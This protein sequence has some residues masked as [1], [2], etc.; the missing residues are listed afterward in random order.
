MI[1]HEC[2]CVNK[3]QDF[4]FREGQT[5]AMQK[6]DGIGPPGDV[7]V[8]EYGWYDEHAGDMMYEKS[9]LTYGISSVDGVL[10]DVVVEVVEGGE[11]ERISA[12]MIGP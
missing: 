7:A 1:I 10:Y 11:D 8:E 5:E 4:D 3:V 6:A 2:S 12:K 9:L